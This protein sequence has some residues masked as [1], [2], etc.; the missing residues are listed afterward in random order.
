MTQKLTLPIPPSAN[1]YWRVVNGRPITSAVARNYKLAAGWMAKEQGVEMVST[2]VYL[3][4]D[5][6]RPRKSG[7]LDN[8]LK[9]LLDAMSGI[10]WE[11]DEQIV[12]IVATRYDD[13]D[14]P[15]VELTFLAEK[16]SER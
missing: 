13:K 16:E 11:D 15:R 1:R 9:V 14:N 10:L 6:F 3:R 8:Y 2:P 7:D 5:V 4:I 12:Q